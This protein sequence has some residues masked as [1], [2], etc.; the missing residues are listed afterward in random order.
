MKK[1]EYINLLK[2][3]LNKLEM[4]NDDYLDYKNN[5]IEILDILKNYKTD[6]FEKS[7]ILFV[8]GFI[9]LINERY[10]IW[11]ILNVLI[12]IN[13]VKYYYCEFNEKKIK[14][15]YE[16]IKN[17]YIKCKD[18]IAKIKNAID[19]LQNISEEEAQKYL[20]YKMGDSKK[21]N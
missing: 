15:D 14:N 6:D 16:Y 13:M 9:G 8:A 3:E 11:L 10:T 20:N 7:V 18:D 5:L 19:F 1:T 2:D 21:F 12:I 17:D 4:S